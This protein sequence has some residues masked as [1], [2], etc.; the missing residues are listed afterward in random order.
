MTEFSQVHATRRCCNAVEPI[1]KPTLQYLKIN[2]MM[3]IEEGRA[4]ERI[5]EA[6]EGPGWSRS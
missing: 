5:I 2:A 1:A 6:M 4:R 3:K